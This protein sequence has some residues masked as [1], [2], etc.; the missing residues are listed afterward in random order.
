MTTHSYRT[1]KVA[2]IAKMR[3]ETEEVPIKN[4]EIIEKLQNLCEVGGF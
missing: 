1:V 4:S 3:D 2:D